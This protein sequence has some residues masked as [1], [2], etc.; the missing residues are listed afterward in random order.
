MYYSPMTNEITENGQE[1]SIIYLHATA[2]LI[3]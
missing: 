2:M 3:S 1:N